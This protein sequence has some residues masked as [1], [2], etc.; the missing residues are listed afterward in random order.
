MATIEKYNN[1][2]FINKKKPSFFKSCMGLCVIAFLER[3][4]K[5]QN[6]FDRLISAGS[7]GE[8]FRAAKA[9]M[10]SSMN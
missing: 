6:F 5:R 10:T 4:K 3:N 2:N 1:N 9:E 8:R 7:K